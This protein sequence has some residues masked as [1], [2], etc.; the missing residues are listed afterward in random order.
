MNMSF[1]IVISLIAL[2]VAL[3]IWVKKYSDKRAEA[4]WNR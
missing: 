4:G 2:L 1:I 3:L